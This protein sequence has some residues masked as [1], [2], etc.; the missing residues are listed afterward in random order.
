MSWFDIV[1]LQGNEDDYVPKEMLE[2]LEESES[3][4]WKYNNFMEELN[5]ETYQLG[6]RMAKVA[7]EDNLDD[8]ATKAIDKFMN[9]SVTGSEHFEDLYQAITDEYHSRQRDAEDEEASGPQLEYGDKNQKTVEALED[10]Q[11]QH[12]E[13]EWTDYRTNRELSAF[14]AAVSRG[15]TD[16]LESDFP[17][18]YLIFNEAGLLNDLE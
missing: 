17:E 18:A 14:M 3:L 10:F 15:D 6:E 11:G 7:Q 8:W 2:L 5:W 12:Y 16:N 9:M 4:E 13:N 1:K